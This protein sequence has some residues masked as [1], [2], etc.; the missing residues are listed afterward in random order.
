MEKEKYAKFIG[1][2]YGGGDVIPE[3]SKV[4]HT[5]KEKNYDGYVGHNTVPVAEKAGEYGQGGIKNK[6]R[7]KEHGGAVFLFSD[8]FV[9]F[10]VAKSL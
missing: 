1:Y 4:K 6:T 10:K 3:K 2:K 7:Q 5:Q 9:F 8:G